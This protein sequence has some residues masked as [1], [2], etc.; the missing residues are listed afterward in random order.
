MIRLFSALIRLH[1]ITPRGL[2]RLCKSL[3][4]EGFTLMAVLRF[5]RYYYGDRCALRLSASSFSS[6]YSVL[7]DQSIR[8][9]ALLHARYDIKKGSRAAILCRNHPQA[10][11][12]LCALSRLGADIKL[13]NT[14][15]TSD[16][17][18][19]LLTTLPHHL[20]LYDEELTDRCLP[21]QS[22]CNHVSI[23]NLAGSSFQEDIRLPHIIKGGHI[24]VF[25]G[26]S[27]GT[28]KEASR[29]TTIM[30]FLLPFMTLLRNVGLH[31]HASV[32]LSLPFYHGFGLSTLIIALVMG[33]KI[34]LAKR[35]DPI[36]TLSVI[37]QE[38]IE[39]LPA[40]PAMLNR[41]LQTCPPTNWSSSLKCILSGGD[42][43][44]QD[45]ARAICMH[46]DIALY[47]LYGTSEAGFFML[48]GPQDLMAFDEPTLGKPIQGVVCRLIDTDQE[49]V[50]TLHVKT[51]WMMAGVSGDG[52][53]TGDRMYRNAQGYY[54][55]RGRADR[56]VV[57]GGENVYPERIESIAR[58]HPEVVDCLAYGVKDPSFGQVIHLK[59]EH[60]Q[61][62]N[63]SEDDLKQWLAS[64]LPRAA[65]PHH[66]VFGSVCLMTTGKRKR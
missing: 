18:A 21:R 36:E 60:R 62:S 26:G 57:C 66:I 48:A 54:F 23:E 19:E 63:L 12:L 40:V 43:L 34:C 59:V 25:T 10:V 39:V 1:L 56:M 27:T 17:I 50:G 3:F 37:N 55:Y 47:N 61:G 58:S 28:G 8:Y 22:I 20:L 53:S 13:I 33:K 31:R 5:A 45:T 42:L 2:F 51:R 49:G 6:T 30:P 32:Y 9:A 29:P 4:H 44:E 64:K 14:D 24:S 65:R 7:Y 16:H 11:T 15:M 38:K 52:I 46:T 35:F 41:M